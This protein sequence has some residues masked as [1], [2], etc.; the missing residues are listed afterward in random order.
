M[1]KL[2]LSLIFGAVFIG[3]GVGVLFMELTE[4]TT[5]EYLPYVKQEKIE[6]FT[7]TDSNIFGESENEK[8]RINIYL[9]KYFEDSG[10]FEIVEDKTVDGVS[11]TV[12]YRGKKPR[13]Y[14]SEHWYDEANQAQ[15]YQLDCYTETYMPKDI[16]DAAKYMFSHKVVVTEP[17]NYLVENV[18][19]K[20]NHPEL[21]LT[22]Y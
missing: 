10:K 21:I 8:A 17:A 16:L 13:F 11:I 6:T 3:A 4:F 1:K 18:V 14:F 9:G 12:S 2:I 7:F 5:A 19:I 15:V 20:T 22:S